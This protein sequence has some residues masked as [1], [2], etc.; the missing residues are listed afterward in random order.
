M[1][2]VSKNE[3]GVAVI[4][5]WDLSGIEDRL[6]NR[7]GHNAAV[8]EQAIEEFKKYMII[9]LETGLERLSMPSEAVDE[10]W[11]QFILFTRE[12]HGFCEA[13]FGRYVHHAPAT[14]NENPSQ[15]ALD[16]FFSLYEERFGPA[17]DLWSRALR[18]DCAS[19]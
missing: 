12:Y 18:S 2:K 5:G 17:P 9:R 10:V 14:T 6:V 4:E 1:N 15:Q 19:E 11:H 16:R 3:F 13:A 7:F 8:V